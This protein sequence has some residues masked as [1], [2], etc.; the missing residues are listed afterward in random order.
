M[1]ISSRPPVAPYRPALK[2]S[3]EVF[4][5]NGELYRSFPN[6]PGYDELFLGSELPLP[7]LSPELQR[8]AA[9][10]LDKPGETEL[11][12]THFSV[13]QN[14]ERRTPMLTAVNL[15]G[16]QIEEVERDG[17]WVFDDRI[18]REH[19]TGNEAYKNNAIDRGHMVRRRDPMWGEKSFEGQDDTFVYTNAAL[20][21]AD[22]NQREWLDLENYI[23]DNAMTYDRKVT[24][25][26]GPVLAADDPKFDNKGK[27][28]TPTRIPQAFFKVVAWKAPSGELKGQGYMMSQKD[29]IKKPQSQEEHE[30]VTNFKVYQVPLEKLEQMTQIDF[31]PLQD[32]TQETRRL[33]QKPV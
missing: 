19:Q 31:G 32:E 12:Y 4:E 6:R 17:K 1:L 16:A 33:G 29:L 20:Q 7:K 24:V 2:T 23:L 14:K 10:R 28:S 25:F 9:T 27:M 22:L 13:I 18:A 30:H 11:E 5:K 21:H 15:D 3:D 8:Q 26:T